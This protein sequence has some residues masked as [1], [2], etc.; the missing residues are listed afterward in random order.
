MRILLLL[1]GIVAA[2]FGGM[3]VSE[4]R[5][6]VHEIE[7]LIAFLIST[8]AFGTF[9]IA[10]GVAVVAARLKPEQPKATGKSIAAIDSDPA[11]KP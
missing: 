2:A 6:A 7:A 1:V 8:V 4:A 11:L 9:A 5:S 10:N 3:V